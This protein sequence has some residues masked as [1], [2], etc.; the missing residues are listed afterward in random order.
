MRAD[1][2]REVGR[3]GLRVLGRVGAGH[4][5]AIHRVAADRIGRNGRDNSR[6]DAAG[7]AEHHGAEAV[8]ADIV[9]RAQD[10]GPP[11]LGLVRDAIGNCRRLR[12]IRGD[13][14]SAGV[15]SLDGHRQ[16]AWICGWCAS[17]SRQCEVGV[18]QALDIL[19]R[20]HEQGALGVH[21]ERVAIEDQL[22][23]RSDGIDV[24]DAGGRLARTPL[25]QRQPDVVLRPLVRRA[26]DVED[27]SDAGVAGYRE[28]AAVLPD[29]LADR[30]GQVDPSIAHH[31]EPIAGHEVAGF[32]EHPVVGQV[33]LVVGR[34]NPAIEQEGGRVAW[35][36]G[37][38]E[39]ADDD[40]DRAQ[41]VLGQI[42]GQLLQRCPGR[43]AER[44]AEHQI[45]GRVPRQ[46]HL[47][48]DHQVRAGRGRLP[49][50]GMD[51]SGIRR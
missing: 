49:G 34:H 17:G 14:R 22:V 38:V 20:A 40:R 36:V 31:D 23:L 15:V 10:Q 7:H 21:R 35:A 41:A 27:Q 3:V 33:V 43:R 50:A 2:L 5:H 42:R 25:Q 51:K 11:H 18:E 32:I 9:T 29:V 4:R 1:S 46:R 26:V 12:V 37:V 48:E 24:H 44:A 47:R 13:R 30:Q 8:L 28:R 6:I 19:R 45:L 16:V 39:V